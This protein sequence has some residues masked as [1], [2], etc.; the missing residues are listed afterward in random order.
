[1]SGRV[2]TKG[3]PCGTNPPYGRNALFAAIFILALLLAACGGSDDPKTLTIFAAASLTN[4]FEALA[5]EFEARNDGVE[6]RLNFASSSALAAQI[7]E[8]ADADLF[9]SANPQQ[10]QHVA[11]ELVGEPQIFAGNRLVVA[12]HAESE[13]DSLEQLTVEGVTIVLAVPEVPI[14]AYTDEVLAML[15]ESGDFA[16]DVLANVVSE[17]ANVR[18]AVLKV[19]L[20]EADVAFAYASD[21]REG[22]RAIH[23]PDEFNV[24]ASYLIAVTSDHALAD[25]FIA[26]VLS[27][28]G[29]AI[30]VEWGFLSAPE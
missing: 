14:R 24:R 1:M 27:D 18:A 25:D 7:N 10:M 23:I 6:V 22:V 19:S 11:D 16:D 20:G 29:Q 30:L 13:I 15:D 17:E 12:T 4:A 3:S 9:A 28:D 26:F 21:I 2:T 5:E 8:G